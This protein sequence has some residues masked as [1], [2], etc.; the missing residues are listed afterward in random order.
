MTGAE[1]DGA[2]KALQERADRLVADTRET[3]AKDAAALVGAL[4]AR[5]GVLARHERTSDLVAS[6][7]FFAAVPFRLEQ[8]DRPGMVYLEN[9]GGHQAVKLM[10]DWN[11][12]GQGICPPGDY[13]LVVAL[14]PRPKP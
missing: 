2:V 1:Y 7:A 10:P 12:H 6:S 8:A 14:I 5:A 4:E 11:N 13:T 3:L 9:G